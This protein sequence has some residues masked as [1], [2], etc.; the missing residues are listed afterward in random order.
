MAKPAKRDGCMLLLIL[1]G[2]GCGAD[3]LLLSGDQIE[4]C[5]GEDSAGAVIEIEKHGSDLIRAKVIDVA[6]GTGEAEVQPGDINEV[7]FTIEFPA[8]VTITYV[9]AL[10]E[11]SSN[12][13][14]HIKGTWTQHPDGVFGADAGTWRVQVNP[15]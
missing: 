10:G 12:S 6:L 1:I 9:G 8:G 11:V 15:D 3:P 5:I 2:T 14:E 4:V 7:S 13:I